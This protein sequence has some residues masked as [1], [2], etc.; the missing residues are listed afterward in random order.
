MAI[1][2]SEQ[3]RKAIEEGKGAPVEMI[4][5]IN[6]SHY[7][8]LPSSAYERIRALLRTED[9]EVSEAYK[10]FGD[11]AAKEGWDDPEM[12]AYDQIDPPRERQ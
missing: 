3:Q 5:P 4:D 8:L 9:F 2:L 1:E 12:A 6:Q 7:V 11:V 10:A